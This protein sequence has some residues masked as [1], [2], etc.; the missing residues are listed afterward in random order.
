MA[1][2]RHAP[3]GLFLLFVFA[4]M[5]FHSGE[6]LFISQGPYGAGKLIVWSLFVGFLAYSVYC[7][8]QENIFRTIKSIFPFHWARQI[9]LDLYLGLTISLFIIY[10]NEGSLLIMAL[11]LLPVLLFANLATLLYFAKNYDSIVSL[12][13]IQA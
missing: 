8:S 7:S 2:Q 5:Y 6:P 13:A 3:W 1:L 4:A 11:W 12:F 10:L 9:G